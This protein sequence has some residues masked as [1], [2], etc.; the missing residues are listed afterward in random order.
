MEDELKKLL[1]ADKKAYAKFM[2]K[3]P[4]LSEQR[5]WEVIR[6]DGIF[7][8]QEVLFGYIVDFYCAKVSLAIE[9]DGSVHADQ[10]ARDKRRDGTFA[11]TASRS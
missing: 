4:T 5:L 10:I 3:C 7:T 9:V 1:M 11:V 2:A 8:K 6:H